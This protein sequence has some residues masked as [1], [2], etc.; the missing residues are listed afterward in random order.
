MEEKL[1]NN[2]VLIYKTH[3]VSVETSEEVYKFV[4]QTNEG[5]CSM[6][7][8]EDQYRKA[9]IGDS[10]ILKTFGNKVVSFGKWI[11]EKTWDTLGWLKD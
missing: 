7:V 1:I 5:I 2:A 8:K 10:G 4:F 6:E 11:Q 9:D 3:G